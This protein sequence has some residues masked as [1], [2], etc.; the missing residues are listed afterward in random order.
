[1]GRL[2]RNSAILAKIET[3]Y[4]TDPTPTGAANAILVSNLSINPLAAQNVKRDLIRPFLGGSDELVGTAY[5]EC[6]F[7]VELQ[8]SGAAGTAPAWGPLL[9][10]VGFAEAVTASARVDYTP[11]SSAFES[12]TIYYHDDGVLHKLLGARGDVSLDIG[13]GNRP[14]LKFKFIGLDGGISATANPS[15]TLTAWK[16]PLAVTDTN[17]ADVTVGCTYS[18][19]ALSGGTVYPSRGLQ[20][21]LGNSVAHTPLLGAETVEIT[22]RDVKGSVEFDLTAAQE[23]TLMATV[24]A[25]TQQGIGLLH[26]TAA[27][28]KVLV[29]GAAMQ[30]T[31][32]KKAEINGKRLIGYDLG[33][34]PSASGNDDLRIVVL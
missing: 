28:Y 7:D 6:S 3:T 21:S 31:N 12:V 33:L 2:I 13:L 30:L 11:I 5:V 4:G 25:A 23:V 8:S 22:Q 1:M 26:G 27:G 10:A 14:V 32:P 34:A 16:A 9:R 20:L 18:A 17:T 19:G 15:L 29:F 24:K